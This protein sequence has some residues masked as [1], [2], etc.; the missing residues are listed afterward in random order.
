MEWSGAVWCGVVSG[1]YRSLNVPSVF[2]SFTAFP[3]QCQCHVI[4]TEDLERNSWVHVSKMFNWMY[5][6][7]LVF[8]LLTH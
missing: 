2:L 6:E 7:I 3:H 8:P 1:V 4:D 5:E